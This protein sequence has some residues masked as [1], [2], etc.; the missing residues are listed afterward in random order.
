MGKI[1]LQFH[2]I[3]TWIASTIWFKHYAIRFRYLWL[4]TD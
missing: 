3:A 1:K 2:S 4:D